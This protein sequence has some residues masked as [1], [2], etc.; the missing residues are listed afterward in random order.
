MAKSRRQQIRER[1][2]D[3]CEY[4]ELPQACTTLPHEVDHIR[5][6]K[7]HG[8]TT[9]ENTCWACAS[10]NAAKGPNA[11][12]YDG[13]TGRLVRLFNPRRDR[14]QEHFAWRGPV[15]V[16]K[17]P[18]GRATIDVL[19]INDAD[20]IEHRHRLIELGEFPPINE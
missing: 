4:C 18:R 16:G 2:Q 12:G 13:V 9:L 7:H 10:C 14:W 3:R 8:P 19:S 20:R 15:L 1:A 6:Q 17:T 11:S 5:A